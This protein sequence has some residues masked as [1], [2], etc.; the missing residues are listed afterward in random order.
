VRPASP[1][2]RLTDLGTLAGDATGIN[3]TRQVYGTDVGG[4]LIGYAGEDY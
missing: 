4:G 1:H 2:R 3:D